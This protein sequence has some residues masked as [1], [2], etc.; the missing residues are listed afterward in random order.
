MILARTLETGL[1]A[2]IESALADPDIGVATVCGG[3][4]VLAMAGLVEDRAIVTHHLGMD[5][6]DA[7]GALGGQRA[8][9]R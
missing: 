4:L 3:S 5:L 1:P 2:I 8:R 7:T 6:L 9:R